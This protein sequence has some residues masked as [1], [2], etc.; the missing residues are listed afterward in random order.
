MSE[1]PSLLLIFAITVTGITANTLVT[2]GIPDILDGVGASRDLAGVFVGAGTLPG[3]LLAPVIGVLADRY[4]R[5]EIIIPCLLLFGLAGAAAFVAS[6][7]WHLV[8]I[9]LLQGTGSAGLI[10]LAV[11]IIGDHWSG[12]RRAELIGRNSA[13]LTVCLALFPLL[14][15]TMTDLWGWRAPFGVYPVAVVT[16][17][18]V[19]RGI[20]RAE[21]R[22]VTFRS[23]LGDALPY[24]RTKGYLAV[25]GAATVAFALI[26][27]AL[28]T[29][30]PLYAE[31]TF[32]LGAT[33][34]G[35]LLGVPAIGSTFSAFNLG[36]IVRRLGRRRT[37]ALTA[38]GFTISLAVIGAAPSLLVLG[39]GAI[40][41]GMSEGATIPMLQDIAAGSGPT[42]SRGALVATQVSAARLGQTIG[43]IAAST[44]YG[45]A[46]GRW[47]FAAGA[48]VAALF[49]GPLTRP[50]ADAVTMDD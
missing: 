15:G 48:V 21:T 8:V 42:A 13:V 40:L 10:N 4:G 35:I 41:F 12:A 39:L 49:L 45:A 37:L 22:D 43:P 19:A 23:Q 44:T 20:P 29:V 11:V 33:Q 6:E 31:A 30:L 16:A 27:G 17:I 2:P 5:R 24:M 46:G 47:T 28:L 7:F 32:G 25:L 18:F 50:A 14:A 26:F 3:I 38:A 1:R 36:R 9:R 34:R